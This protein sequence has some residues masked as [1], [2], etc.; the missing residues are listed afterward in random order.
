MYVDVSVSSP[1]KSFM[2]ILHTN[3][4][5]I[6]LSSKHII[7]DCKSTSLV[8]FLGW[9]H[10]RGLT[11]CL[12]N[13]LSTHI[14][15]LF[16]VCFNKKSCYVCY[17]GW[18]LCELLWV[19]YASTPQ[20]RTIPNMLQFLNATIL[21]N[22]NVLDLASGKHWQKHCFFDSPKNTSPGQLAQRRG[23]WVYC[24][25]L[26]RVLLRFGT[27]AGYRE[28]Y[29]DRQLLYSAATLSIVAHLCDSIIT[30][31]SSSLSRKLRQV[32]SSKNG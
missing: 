12:F 17:Y 11:K 25:S 15:T 4:C 7:I 6:E 26:K 13:A 9:V 16:V 22:L 31:L 19:L 1:Q 2:F 32:T 24:M 30:P 21:A 18:L 14:A 8:H 29:N 27:L 23:R 28:Q 5:W 10:P 20:T 3:M